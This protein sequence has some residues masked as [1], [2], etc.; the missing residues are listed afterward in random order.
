MQTNMFSALSGHRTLIKQLLVREIS[1]RYRGSVMGF[2]WSLVTPIIMLCIYTFVF[3][4]IFKAKWSIPSADG[5][6]LNFAMV[7]FL[8]LLIH[9]MIAEILSRSP[10]LIIENVNWVKLETCP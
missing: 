9:G 1:S 4:Y 6:V 8:G 5:D 2:L 3:K 10:G 7:L